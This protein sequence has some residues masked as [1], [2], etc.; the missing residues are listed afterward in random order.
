MKKIIIL[1]TFGIL[2]IPSFGQI[3][4]IKV[5][6][7]DNLEIN[8]LSYDSLENDIKYDVVGKLIGQE[9]FVKPPKDEFYRN[10][11]YSG[12]LINYKKSETEEDN[13]YE[14][15][16][17]HGHTKYEALSGKYF[18]VI[19]AYQHPRLNE[20]PSM[21]S[22]F[23]FLK[24]KSKENGDE[25][26]YFYPS[27]LSSD[28]I[29]LGYFEKQK[30][31]LIGKKF[32]M[33]NRRFGS[34]I[35]INTG[36]VI[37]I[38]SGTI[39][40]CVSLGIEPESSAIALVLEG[41]DASKIYVDVSWLEYKMYAFEYSDAEY[42][43]KSFGDEY[44]QLILDDNVKIGMTKEMAKLAWGRPNKINNTTTA[45]TVDEQWVYDKGNLYFTN[46]ILTTIQ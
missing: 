28:M 13:V 5:T 26:Y 30:Q 2:I 46:N 36:K 34:Y 12:F 8:A 38:K 33:R 24:L 42:L 37:N 43:K 6:K 3:S 9:L 1:L 17:K 16:S 14:C 20:N 45:N 18:K 4:T 7:S 27:K 40:N 32:L 11:G 31:L 25:F 10:M 41:S 19:A 15:C 44:W 22:Q 23:P 29:I 35:D 39:L 21:Y